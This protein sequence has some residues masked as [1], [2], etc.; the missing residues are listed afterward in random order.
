MIRTLYT[1]RQLSKN[2]NQW[3]LGVVKDLIQIDYCGHFRLKE[4]NHYPTLDTTAL[5]SEVIG[6]V[7]TTWNVPATDLP[8]MCLTRKA[9]G[10]YRKQVY[11]HMNLK[12]KVYK[13]V[14]FN[15][16]NQEQSIGLLRARG[17]PVLGRIWTD[18]KFSKILT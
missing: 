11:I 14:M 4:V 12:S 6:F 18:T 2:W 9:L 16:F 7:Y 3:W 5:S 10:N 1:A 13:P 8:V 17:Q 15:V